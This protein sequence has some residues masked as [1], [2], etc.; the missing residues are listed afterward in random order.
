MTCVLFGQVCGIMLP[1]SRGKRILALSIQS[2]Q[3]K[4]LKQV[5]TSDPHESQSQN[6]VDDPS[7]LGISASQLI[8]VPQDANIS[9]SLSES[10]SDLPDVSSSLKVANFIL[11]HD[12]DCDNS[13]DHCNPNLQ[14][15]ENLDVN[16]ETNTEDFVTEN[17]KAD[18][19]GVLDNDRTVEVETNSDV[20]DY[21]QVINKQTNT[22][23]AVT[24]NPKADDV[25]F[26][27]IYEEVASYDHTQLQKDGALDKER[28]VGQETNVEVIGGVQAVHKTPDL[29]KD[30]GIECA[31]NTRINEEVNTNELG[32][33]REESDKQ[34]VKKAKAKTKKQ[35]KK[36]NR[37]HGKTYVGRSFD[38]EKGK[39]VEV[40][41][42]G[43][44]LGERCQCK[45][46]YYKCKN[47]TDEDRRKIFSD[48]WKMSW[49]E[50]EIFVK[51]AIETKDVKERKGTEEQSRRNKTLIFMLRGSTGAH[52]V[53]K[54][55]FLKTT[56]LKS[57]WVVKTVTGETS[58]GIRLSESSDLDKNSSTASSK[59]KSKMSPSEGRLFLKE[60]FNILPKMPAHYCRKD[61]SKLY[62]EA[63]FRSHADV[64]REYSKRCVA[65]GKQVMSMTV[66][67][68]ELKAANI[69]IFTPR[70]DQCD[71]C[72][73]FMQGNTSEEVYRE[74][75]TR[76]ET[77]QA[78][79][80]K[81]KTENV[82]SRT[83]VLCMD[84]QR[85]LLSP[86]LK[87]SALYYKTKLQVHNYTIYDLCNKD[88]TCFVWNEVEGGLSA[89]EFASCLF[90]YLERQMDLFDRVI[91]YSDGCTYQNRNRIMATALR[92]FSTKY[93]KIVEQKILE[94]GHTQMEV[95][96]V[97]ATIERGLKNVDIFSPLDY[98]QLIQA[99]RKNPKPYEVEY[100][101][102]DFYLDFENYGDGA[103]K[104]LKPG[105]DANVNN[106]CALQYNPDG[107]I[108]YKLNFGDEWME[109]GRRNKLP[110][111][112]PSQLYNNRRKIKKTKYDHLQSLKHVLPSDV[113]GFYDSLPHT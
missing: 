86:C 8:E 7:I 19:D 75:R 59:G 15:S 79:K 68:E 17:T 37:Q 99:A 91:I 83:K 58:N 62:L 39:F 1:Y 48:V 98:V 81:D 55:M 24:E 78:E 76:K 96:S 108:C 29:R 82:G 80:T 54:D 103:I 72:C 84:V 11:N 34:S 66:F 57:W 44:V 53:C 22:E 60:F 107:S 13:V 71:L 14:N 16:N 95:D 101:T 64:Y 69:G 73:E 50:K 105:K 90:V 65:E 94:R 89:N 43:K 77:A 9:F 104:S 6:E 21:G 10:F 25:G 28:A 51:M 38:K 32:D 70:K 35:E 31:T 26:D 2:T 113:H 20:I 102:Y 63:T 46:A 87:A 92:Y 12:N 106:I 85:V 61:T 109:L 74:H 40:I 67:S 3:A 27:D 52:R 100:L 49:S 41:K 110:T 4:R 42:E 5:Q 36:E 111:N 47:V 33:A 112:V 30:D 18:D 23:D 88:V 45:A 56:G 97:H 93:H